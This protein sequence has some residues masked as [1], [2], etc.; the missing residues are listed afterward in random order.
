MR[1]PLAAL[2]VA[3]LMGGALAVGLAAPTPSNADPTTATLAEAALTPMGT[4]VASGTRTAGGTIT[5]VITNDALPLIF[6]VSDGENP[7]P[8]CV[9]ADASDVELEWSCTVPLTDFPG[10]YVSPSAPWSFDITEFPDGPEPG[11]SVELPFSVTIPTPTVTISSPTTAYPSSIITVNGTKAV[12]S[13]VTVAAFRADGEGSIPLRDFCDDSVIADAPGGGFAGT[14]TTSWSCDIPASVLFEGRTAGAWTIQAVQRYYQVAGDP[15]PGLPIGALQIPGT[16]LPVTVTALDER[17][18]VTF[19]AVG[20]APIIAATPPVPLAGEPAFTAELLITPLD[21]QGPITPDCNGLA[22]C[23]IS[24][25][26]PG[27]YF[28]EAISTRSGQ[29]SDPALFAF[30]MPARPTIQTVTVTDGVATVVGTATPERS[31]LVLLSTGEIQCGATAQADGSFTCVTPALPAGGYEFTAVALSGAPLI[32]GDDQTT[33]TGIPS[34]RADAFSAT[35]AELV[36]PAP[37]VT[38]PPA[39][40]PPVTAPPAASAPPAPPQP[41]VTPSPLPGLPA[42]A[43]EPIVTSAAVPAIVT[44]A[45]TET[46]ETVDAPEA[47][48]PTED[49]ATEESP[50]TEQPTSSDGDGTTEAGGAT[51]GSSTANDRNDLAAPSAFTS[52]LPTVRSLADNPVLLAG[53]FGFALLVMLLLAIPAELLTSTLASSEHRLGAGYRRAQAVFSTL[54]ERFAAVVRSSAVRIGAM[55]AAMAVIFSFADPEYG[56]DL[57]SLRLTASIALSLFVLYYLGARLTQI[58]VYRVWGMPGAIEALPTALLLAV[59]GVVVARV[60][61]FAPGFLIGLAIGF[62]VL[63]ETNARDRMRVALVTLGVTFAIALGAWLAY[64]AVSS[65]PGAT[66]SVLGVFTIDTLVGVTA[67]G[68]TGLIIVLLPLTFFDGH[69]IWQQSKKIWVAA[70]LV[71]VTAFAAV[72][73]P[74]SFDEFSA[75]NELVVWLIPVVI[76]GVIAFS[77]WAWLRREPVAAGTPVDEEAT[78]PAPVGR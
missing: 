45:T 36:L 43:A 54:A 58:I 67:E 57:V 33:I 35:V 53:A 9:N 55:I 4:L 73:L 46:P 8:Y 25:A 18:T 77:L 42:I 75:V 5:A 10:G 62:S 44:A 7:S 16:Q 51:P 14:P 6:T 60:I 56:F 39:I 32:D 70:Y 50:A 20:D 13:G 21:G 52:A 19:P 23:D 68:L 37:P 29:L 61:D 12:N 24:A 63:V 48:A 40:D 15:D 22:T 17:P 47:E 59:V 72:V 2:A 26:E 31:V 76:F 78:P 65:I 49:G 27:A 34:A 3:A 1:R 30:E 41:S 69:A 38:D 11:V 74:A 28:V 66:E 64:S 71:A